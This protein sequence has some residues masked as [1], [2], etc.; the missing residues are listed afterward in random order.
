[1]E[2]RGRDLTLDRLDAGFTGVQV[3]LL[4]DMELGDAD[5]REPHRHDY[6]ELI[7]VRSGEGEHLL[8]G[9]PTPVVERSVTV[10]GRGQVHVF[11]RAKRLHGAVVRFGEELLLGG[12]PA[13]EGLLTGR[14]G[15]TVTVPVGE[16]GALESVVRALHSEIRRPP[17]AASS[18]LERH[19]IAVLLLWIDRWHGAARPEGPDGDDAD[20]RLQR[21]FTRQLEAGFARHHDA[22]HYADALAVPA[23]ALSRALTRT[24]GRTTKELI[25][26]R[27]M[28]EAARLLRFTDLSVQEIAQRTGFADPLYFSRAF[29]RH[30][31]D[32][33][34]AYRARVEGKSM[35]S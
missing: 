3:L 25:T 34:Q 33:P 12:R 27:V 1:M 11:A 13:P 24:T 28:L 23:A 22:A 15:L 10:I 6:H 21:R 16:V 30:F 8:D 18:E 32:A 4:D 29:K 14:G 2:E 17:D 5:V 19:L 9:E 35:S 31:G 7:W 26:D 20:V